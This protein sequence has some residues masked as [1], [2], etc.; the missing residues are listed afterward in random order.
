MKM[1]VP[2]I[3][4]DVL[5]KRTR[6]ALDTANGSPLKD[7]AKADSKVQDIILTQ[8]GEGARSWYEF[9]KSKRFQNEIETNEYIKYASDDVNINIDTL[10]K[11]KWNF[12]VKDILIHRDGI[13]ITTNNQV[14]T[15]PKESCIGNII[16]DYQFKLGMADISI[17]Q[18]KRLLNSCEQALE[19]AQ[20]ETL[21]SN[22]WRNSNLAIPMM[23]EA[24]NDF[25]C[26]YQDKIKISIESGNSFYDDVTEEISE[27]F[28]NHHEIV[29]EKDEYLKNLITGFSEQRLKIDLD[30]I[31]EMEFGKIGYK[32]FSDMQNKVYGA[33]YVELTKDSIYELSQLIR[34]NDE[35]KEW[36]FENLKSFINNNVKNI[37]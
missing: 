23:I 25:I 29:Y 26:Q 15:I 7:G 22:D 30:Y 20:N 35:N 10:T 24:M 19:E 37:F 2:A 5:F 36:N 1:K 32:T 6:T 3:E 28:L 16:K 17:E 18:G 4:L 13:D 34:N 12:N 31:H 9:L 11:H 27:F 14:Y 33:A 8:H 21:K